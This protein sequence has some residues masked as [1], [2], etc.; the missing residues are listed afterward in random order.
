MNKTPAKKPI[1]AVFFDID[2]TLVS[3]ETHRMPESAVRA[4]KLLKKKG[5]RLFIATGRP[6]I[7]LQP[8]IAQ[9]DDI[10]FDGMVTINGQ[11]CTTSN[12]VIRSTPIPVQTMETL[13]P[14]LDQNNIAC[15][16]VE[17][18]Y[19]YLNR[20]SPAVDLVR[21]HYASGLQKP[22]PVDSTDRIYS[23][24]VYQ[25]NP[26][27]DAGQ[28]QD[29]LDH[30]PG[31]RLVR[32]NPMFSDAIPENGSK[33]EGIIAVLDA[34]GLS[35]EECAA[36][37][38]GEN[39]IEMLQTAGIGVAMG[40]AEIVRQAAD[41]CAGTPDENGLVEG[42]RKAGLLTDAEADEAL[43]LSDQQLR[44]NGK[45]IKAAFF[46][47]DGTL[48][49][50]T[51][52]DI[53][54]ST[55]K[56]LKLLQQN[57]IRI[58]LAT[59]RPPEHMVHVP[60][61]DTIGFDGTVALNGQYCTVGDQVIRDVCIPEENLNQL[62]PWLE[63]SHTACSFFELEYS[64]LN[65]TSDK[66]EEL[67]KFLGPTA[68]T[69]PVNSTDRISDHK[70]YQLNGYIGPED[71]QEFLSHIPGCQAVRW[72]NIFADIIPADGGKPNGLQSVLEH[73]GLNREQ[74]IAF[75]DGGNDAD[76]LRYA[77]IG[78]AMGNAGTEAREAADYITDSVDD[79]GIFKALV[80]LGILSDSEKTI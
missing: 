78:I 29:F 77:G 15:K 59:G 73:Y 38:D 30:A 27:I 40:D 69:M 16:F 13:I 62:V 47:I 3:F 45:N 44:E 34:F 2:G 9:F 49:S 70:V 6:P 53:P 68:H 66:T 35:T 25:L 52:H 60:H 72:N 51:T 36:F 79:N 43:G 28:E 8:Q 42:L 61:I 58:F 20:L 65:F 71:E 56:A 14:W 57:D 31:L 26:Y 48:V 1:K 37:G 24:K 50:F 67:E 64:Y 5:I 18:D 21:S 10:G 75:G 33:A 22:E 54:E 7:Q 12:E 63:D 11:L 17:A 46:D 55:L 32:W 39:D 4:L 74:S 23:H 19:S 76:M 80:H 41:Y